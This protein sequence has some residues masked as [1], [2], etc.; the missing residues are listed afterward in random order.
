MGNRR[1]KFLAGIIFSSLLICQT[2]L[3][4]VSASLNFPLT[5]LQEEKLGFYDEHGFLISKVNGELTSFDVRYV[6]DET[7]KTN[8]RI[9]DNVKIIGKG[10]FSG[11]FLTDGTVII[12][13]GGR[14]IQTAYIPRSV[15]EIGMNA[16]RDCTELTT[17]KFGKNLPYDNFHNLTLGEAAFKG[18]TSLKSL[19]MSDLDRVNIVGPNLFEGC[20]SLQSVNLSDALTEIP[21]NM[22]KDCTSLKYIYISNNVTSISDSAFDGTKNLTIYCESGSTAAKFAEDNK[23]LKKFTNA[24]GYEKE[25][26]NIE[27]GVELVNNRILKYHDEE[28]FNLQ[29]TYTGD[30]I[31]SYIPENSNIVSVDD[32]GLVSI[33]GI[34]S[35]YIYIEVTETKIFDR[36]YLRVP[37]TIT[38][39]GK[40]PEIPPEENPENP[41]EPVNPDNPENPDNPDNPNPSPGGDTDSGNNSG[42]GS[43]ENPGNGDSSLSNEQKVEVKRIEVTYGDSPFVIQ[44]GK[45][46][47]KKVSFST[48]N[49]KVFTVSTKGKITI[50]GCGLAKLKMKSKTM[51]KT[52]E[53]VVKPQRNTITSLQTEKRN[54]NVKYKKDK[55]ADGYYIYYAT[56]SKFKKN[57]KKVKVSKNKTTE[58]TVK[59]LKSGKKYYVKVYSFK[60]SGKSIILSDSSKVKTIIVK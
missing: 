27:L 39:R 42:E 49:K 1:I 56:D 43:T 55:K 24:S 38:E 21:D 50:K 47:G 52:F 10:A 11:N 17:V 37:I 60:K 9:P 15:D 48:S 13:E 2:E 12:N 41:E 25:K 18:C 26:Q 29:A 34:G 30:G 7:E 36:G 16:F 3:I 8:I 54:F 45:D 32:N 14:K 44:P 53:I 19:D 33:K 46:M 20:T 5:E 51:T 57:L 59:K 58:Y 23:I 40:E 22:F 35:T 4:P 28:D 6:V 31:I